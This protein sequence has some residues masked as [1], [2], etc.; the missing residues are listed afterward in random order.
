MLH[1]NQCHELLLQRY[2]FY[3]IYIIYILF[4]THYIYI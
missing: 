3:Y 1:L 2:T 4:L